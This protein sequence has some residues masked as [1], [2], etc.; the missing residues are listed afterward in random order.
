MCMFPDVRKARLS[1]MTKS[2][3]KAASRIIWNVGCSDE[4]GVRMLLKNDSRPEESLSCPVVAVGDS[5]SS[6]FDIVY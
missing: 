6:V 4:P 5:V 2:E 3:A 1:R